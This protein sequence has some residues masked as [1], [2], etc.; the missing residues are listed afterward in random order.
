MTSTISRPAA[1]LIANVARAIAAASLPGRT[2]RSLPVGK[3]P[4]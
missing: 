1:D 3:S 2:G 4:C